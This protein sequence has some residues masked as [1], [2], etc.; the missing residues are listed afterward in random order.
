M[1]KDGINYLYLVFVDSDAVLE[2]VSDYGFSSHAG[3]FFQCLFL[4]L[5]RVPLIECQRGK[6][7]RRCVTF[8]G[9]GPWETFEGYLLRWQPAV[10]FPRHPETQYNQ[11]QEVQLTYNYNLVAVG[12]TAFH[13]EA[14][15]ALLPYNTGCVFTDIGYMFNL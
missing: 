5:N 8:E 1:L 4:H 6:T 13:R 3:P 10:G 9:I 14:V 2:E 12:V 7:L 15:G 11:A